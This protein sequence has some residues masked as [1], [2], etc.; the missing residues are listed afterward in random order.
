MVLRYVHVAIVG[1]KGKTVDEHGKRER[2]RG[3]EFLYCAVQCKVTSVFVRSTHICE[4]SCFNA[5]QI[6]MR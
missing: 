4:S 5:D 1:R 2:E 6:V 3:I